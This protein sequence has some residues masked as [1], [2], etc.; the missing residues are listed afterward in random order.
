MSRVLLHLVARYV[1]NDPRIVRQPPGPIVSPE[2]YRS[3]E[4]TKRKIL[5]N[6][7]LI[8]SFL[9]F[10]VK[11]KWDKVYSNNMKGCVIFRGIFAFIYKS[12]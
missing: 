11:L 1:R 9:T 5:S 4:F 6:Y 8:F 2:I 10:I 12:E 7:F 3:S